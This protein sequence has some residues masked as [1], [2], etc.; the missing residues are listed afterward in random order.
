MTTARYIGG[1]TLGPLYYFQGVFRKYPSVKLKM[2][3]GS[4]YKIQKKY[5]KEI[6]GEKP[7]KSNFV[8]VFPYSFITYRINDINCFLQGCCYSTSC[9]TK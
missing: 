8:N 3:H 9:L 1:S 5:L 7:K 6:P 2:F 4:K